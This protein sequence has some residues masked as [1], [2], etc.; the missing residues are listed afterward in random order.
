MTSYPLVPAEAGTQAFSVSSLHRPA[1]AATSQH[2]QAWVP[3][4]AGMSGLGI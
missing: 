4:F 1:P 2:K 3:A